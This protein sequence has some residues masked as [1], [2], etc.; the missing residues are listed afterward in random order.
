MFW[1][2]ESVPN[3]I[4]WLYDGKEKRSVSCEELLDDIRIIE[5][6][7]NSDQKLLVALFCDN[8]P[9]SV[10][11]YLAV[12][13]SG[14]AVMLINASTD[15]SLKKR[16]LQIY[17]PEIIIYNGEIPEMLME[18][19]K[20]L[21]QLAARFSVALAQRPS[22]SAIHPETGVLLSTSGTIGSPKLVRL[23]YKNIQSNAEAIADYL[24]ITTTEIAITSLPLSYSYGLSVLNSHLL[25][26]GGLVCTNASVVTKDFWSLFKECGCTSFAGVPFSYLMLEKLC[27]GQMELPLLRTLTQAGGRLDAEKIRLFAAIAQRRNYRF[28]V[29]YGQTEATAR[30]SY[31]PFERLMEK[32][33]SV[34]IAIPGGNI[35]IV[36]DGRLVSEPQVEGEIVYE[37]DN[38]M[39]GYA[40]TRAC[41]A[42]PD[43]QRG[44]INTGD[45]GYKD[46][47][48]YLYIT[49]R[50][51]RF[52]KVFGLRLNLD[53]IELMLESIIECPVVC[54]GN[55]E[56][57]HLFIESLNDKDALEA[58]KHI[59]DLYQL[60]HSVVHAHRMASLPLTSAG[61]KDY[62]AI[63]RELTPSGHN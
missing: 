4:A 35:V 5:R 17:T 10:A 23:S 61:K 24:D 18:G 57:L 53:E 46:G 3:S 38:V 11:A 44:R 43:E 31:V 26:G 60:H 28:F 8:S 42:K 47:D 33:G 22:C 14:Y 25:S 19:Y 49:G 40:E 16:I 30:I 51:R 13:R 62:R 37:G 55:D 56:D 39:Q 36:K 21:F 48:G 27:F 29:M 7:I 45:I 32:I 12:L 9:M 58:K 2:M 54:I 52:V 63:E 1:Q 34:G 50:L 20:S 59:I 6:A 15:I 41:L